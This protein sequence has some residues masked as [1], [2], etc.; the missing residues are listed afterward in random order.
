MVRTRKAAEARNFDQECKCEIHATVCEIYGE[1][2]RRIFNV[3]KTHEF[4]IRALR[5]LIERKLVSER[6]KYLCNLCINHGKTF[7]PSVP[8]VPTAVHLVGDLHEENV[9]N[10]VSEEEVE[11][12]Q[13][14][15][16]VIEKL[17][18]FKRKS[19]AV[20]ERVQ[21]L[22]AVIGRTLVAPNIINEYPMLQSKY[23]DIPYME[24]LNT[25]DFL[26]ERDGILVS[27]LRLLVL[28]SKQDS[29]QLAI[30]IESIYHL[31]NNNLIL[32]HNFLANLIQTF[33]L[34]SKTVTTINGK[35]IGG[36]SDTTYRRWLNKN[37]RQIEFPNEDSDI[38]VDNVGKYIVKSYR[39]NHTENTTPT[40]VTA[41]IN[42]PLNK[43]DED[44]DVHLQSDPGLKPIFWMGNANETEIQE[45]MDET[46][47]EGID[48][49][50]QYRYN[51]LCEI[52]KLMATSHDMENKIEEEIIKLNSPGSRVCQNPSCNQHYES[53]KRK[54]ERCKSKVV[55][56]IED[57]EIPNVDIGSKLPKYFQVGESLIPNHVDITM[58]ETIPV[59]PNSYANMEV[60]LESLKDQLITTKK[61]EWV[62][63]GADGPPYTLMRRLIKDKKY[64]L[65]SVTSGF[66]H[67]N[68][69]QLKTFFVAAADICFDVLGQD[70]LNFK[71]PKA[72]DYFISCKDTH[73]S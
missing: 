62:F 7:L 43:P 4:S 45:L 35:I 68:M 71:S 47:Q 28:S 65:V 69:N 61:K 25:K 63:I 38:F 46:M 21:A 36:G 54:C 11:L 27:F 30:A 1:P 39:V 67:L 56:E 37:A 66:G 70:V 55:K 60:I 29:Y 52:F 44:K 17:S 10:P 58:G 24:T 64:D 13:L 16:N 20:N 19:P 49:F 15:D 6:A 57:T 51:Y 72:Y 31:R 8:D 18:S 32:P 33:V 42:I 2:V 12:V 9:Q 5:C 50:R 23:K 34:G 73:K 14:L 41:C 3:K 22:V 48:D 59:N 40:V 53:L 26:D